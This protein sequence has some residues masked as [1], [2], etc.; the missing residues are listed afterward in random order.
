GWDG[1]GGF[2]DAASTAQRRETLAQS[3][4]DLLL[5]YDLDGI[6]LDWE[7][8]VSGGSGTHRPQDKQNF[9]LLLKT[10]RQKL[11]QQGR[12][13][14]KS[15]C[16]SIAGGFAYSYLNNIEPQ[17]VAETVDH[18]FLMT[19]DFHGPWEPSTGFNAPLYAG[20]GGG[21]DAVVSAW[22]KRGVPANK[23]VLGMPMF[24][25]IYQGVNS[26]GLNSSY[27]SGKSISYDAIKRAYLNNTA[28]RQVRHSEAEVPYLVG[29]GVFLSYD[30][31]TSI[32]AKVS[33]A[34]ERGLGGF[35]FWELSQD[36][37]GDL[38]KSALTV[39][40]S[41]G[42]FR[43]VPSDSWYA[44]A[45]VEVSSVG[46]MYGTAPGVF[47]PS[48]AVTRG[49]IVT[50]LHRLA[51][52]SA[53]SGAVRFPDISAGSYYAQAVSWA[54][55]KGIVKGFPDGTFRPDRAISREQ[56]VTILWRYTDMRGVDN[57]RRASLRDF[58]DAVAVSDYAYEPLCWAI[59][60][61]VLKGTAEGL[62]NPS[63]TATRAQTA[64]IFSRFC[65]LVGA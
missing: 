43:D 50:I 42:G 36:R 56:L 46:L 27:S 13:D 53:A 12:Q 32:A 59:G 34:K 54:A 45:V 22:L 7:Y 18:I 9:T 26:G 24:G 28:Y 48:Q 60:T 20:S 62:L 1:S 25:Y 64:V 5:A 52:E 29:N 37:S 16:L 8:P 38:L 17:A 57:G 4:L 21:V 58:R 61:G 23:L 19:Y 47:S 35:G 3:C 14:G 30:D 55:D 40:N 49:Q 6:D 44:S 65:R 63:G 41:A 51:G 33:L 2:S 15:Y 31:E 11:D 10:L 39:W